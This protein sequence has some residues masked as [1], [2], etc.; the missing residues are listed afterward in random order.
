[1]TLATGREPERAGSWS[2]DPAIDADGST[3]APGDTNGVPD[4][5]VHAG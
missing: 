4:V 5:F 2:N 1:V 3:I